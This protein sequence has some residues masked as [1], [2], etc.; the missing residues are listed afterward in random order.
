MANMMTVGE[1]EARLFEAFPRDDAEG[2]DQPGL[3]VG[4]RDTHVERIAFNL[5]MSC[6][7]VVEAHKRGCKTLV[8]HHPP[9]IKSGPTE[10]GPQGQAATSGPGRMLFE[11]ARR[12]VNVIAMHTNADRSVAVRE[13]FAQLLGCACLGNFEHLM[14][15]RRE[16]QGTGFGALLE[17][18][19]DGAHTLAELGGRCATALG[20]A[21]RVWG[22]PERPVKRIAYL[23]GSWGEPELYGICV[24]E[25]IDV[26][27]VG[28]TKY[29]MCVD[30]KPHLAVIDLG[31]DISE[32]PIVDVLLNTVEGFGVAAGD[33]ELLDCTRNNWYCALEGA[34]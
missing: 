26:M 11:A 21:P 20:G 28:E 22:E 8:T 19:W 12:G 10:L 18:A 33:L 4:D 16:A 3:A 1:L 24:R 30:A 14:D 15:A 13:H 7:A 5:D 23:N 2:W 31:H 32:L 17:P 27:V 29:H 34:C 25:G 9:F 6:E